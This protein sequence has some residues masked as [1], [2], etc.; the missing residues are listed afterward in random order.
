VAFDADDRA[1]LNQ[2][3]DYYHQRLQAT[4]EAAAYLKARGLAHPELVATF[5]LGVIARWA[6]ACPRR[7]SRL[8]PTSAPGCR[9]WA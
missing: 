1:L 4:T 7:R 6:Y 5:K 3:I 8:A 2:T 9:R